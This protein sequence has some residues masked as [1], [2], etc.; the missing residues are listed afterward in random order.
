MTRK[1]KELF[2]E[3]RDMD[4]RYIEQLRI[5]LERELKRKKGL[6]YSDIREEY[7]QRS[8]GRKKI[9]IELLEMQLDYLNTINENYIYTKALKVLKNSYNVDCYLSEN[10]IYITTWNQSLKDSYDFEL[11]KD[12]IKDLAKEYKK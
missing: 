1:L 11:S 12:Q 9:E 2:K 3:L 10:R 6:L 4:E 5:D 8:I 7:F